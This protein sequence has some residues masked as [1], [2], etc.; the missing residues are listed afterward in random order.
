MNIF[1]IGVAHKGNGGLL[2]SPYME[3]ELKLLGVTP[4]TLVA[5]DDIQLE[6]HFAKAAGEGGLILAPL[7]G[8]RQVDQLVLENI[9]KICGAPLEVHREAL[10]R[11]SRRLSPQEAE[12][13]ATLP[14]GAHI[15]AFHGSERP[16]FQI[17]GKNFK[18]IVLPADPVEQTGLFFS[19]IFPMFAKAQQSSCIVRVVRVM[20]LSVPQVEGALKD[21]LPSPNPTVAVYPKAAEV[22]IRI[23]AR[24]KDR[25]EAAAACGIVMKAVIERLGGYVYGVDVNSVEHALVQKAAQKGIS[26]AIAESGTREKAARRLGQVPGGKELMAFHF[27]CNADPSLGKTMDISDKLLKKWGI[28]SPQAASAMADSAASQ[29]ENTIGVGITLPT[30]EVKSTMAYV[31]AAMNGQVLTAEIPVA[32]SRSVGQLT[33]ACVSQAMNLARKLTDAYPAVPKGALPLEEAVAA[34]AKAATA[35]TAAN[36]AGE[37]IEQKGSEPMAVKPQAPKRSTK[38]KQPFIKSLAQA[39]LPQ[40]GDAKAEKARKVGI[41]LCFCVFLGSMSYLIYHAQKGINAGKENSRLNDMLAQA[42]AGNLKVDKDKLA[43]VPQE[44]IDKY[45]P[46]VA[47]NE[48]M[49]GWIKID[50]TDL[51]YPVV[52]AEDNEFYHRK[53]FEGDYDYYG[54]PYL[55]FECNIDV[56]DVSDNLIVY[57]HN[58]GN[59]GLMF[60]PVTYY[61]QLD[62]YKQ[63]PV[64]NFDTIYQEGAYKI[65]GVFIANAQPEQDNG[66]VFHYQRFVESKDEEAFNSFVNEVRRRSMYDIDVDVKPGDKLLTLSTC[67]YDFRPEA[68]CVVVARKVRDGEDAKVNTDAAVIN[69]DA[70]FPQAYYAAKEEAAKYGQV[71]GIKIEGK[72]ELTMNVGETTQLKAITEPTTAPINTATWDSSNSSVVTV[73]KHT[74]LVTAVGPGEAVVTAMADDGGYA[75]SV[76]ITVKSKDSLQYLGL[77]PEALSMQMGKEDRITA[78]VTPEGAQVD[79][80]WSVSDSSKLYTAVS[81]SNNKALNLQALAEGTVTVTVTDKISGKQASCE[82]TI[83]PA[84]QITGI[85][86]RNNSSTIATGEVCTVEV[87]ATPE[88]AKLP[89]NAVIEWILEDGTI[90]TAKGETSAGKNATRASNTFTGAKAGTTRMYARIKGTDMETD[91]YYTF[92]VTSTQVSLTLPESITVQPNGSVALAVGVNPPEQAQNLQATSKGSLISIESNGITGGGTA[93]FTVTAGSKT[94]EDTIIFTINGSEVGRCKVVVK[95]DVAAPQSVTVS[96]VSTEVG[97]TVDVQFEVT[98]SGQNG[99]QY[100]YSVDD[101]RVATVN[102]NGQVTGVSAGKTKITVTVADANGKNAVSGTANVTVTAAAP[103]VCSECKQPLT[104]KHTPGCSLD[105]T[106]VCS[107]C[108]TP[109]GKHTDTCSKNPNKPAEPETVECEYCK[110]K[111]G[112][113][114]IEQHKKECPARPCDCG[115]TYSSHNPGCTVDPAQICSE[116]NIP[117]GGHTDACT[118]NPNYK[119][120]EGGDNTQSE[121]DTQGSAEA[122]PANPPA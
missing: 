60:N 49:R 70:Y 106:Q 51:S 56:A 13:L 120:P 40:R 2:A 41:L 121:D 73:D 53:N 36:V 43:Q 83:H 80:E 4:A 81:K 114:D 115:G 97:L 8:S 89:D 113:N 94:G 93:N 108:K 35:A 5:K 24:A 34:G 74:G 54:V 7:T 109:G 22:V 38:K 92:T 6:S 111:V 58:I 99:F 20:E 95:S 102:G 16:P 96:P 29:K 46:F 105:P 77:D 21:I 76:K 117:G 110:E 10:S 78:V 55:D 27:C 75:A 107:E 112:K 87:A 17:D 23:A 66:T 62:F 25:Q 85:T 64:V 67:T 116:C 30:P 14:K 61:K 3:K 72:T 104:G 118:K 19:Y 47:I 103:Q 11:M 59:D 52:Q 79:L 88:G 26:L 69:A 90:V 100:S 28:V 101:T 98:P 84:T 68:R 37:E 1:T 18:I 119:P 42:E 39:L 44:V 31:A 32:G 82:V 48:D 50:G 15:F 65:F 12:Q 57:G 63:H 9:A 45:K 33:E 122:P 86:F 71:K 91:G